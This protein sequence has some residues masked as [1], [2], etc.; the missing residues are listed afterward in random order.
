MKRLVFSSEFYYIKAVDLKKLPLKDK[1]LQPKKHQDIPLVLLRKE[2]NA[3]LVDA[4]KIV[5]AAKD[6]DFIKV[7]IIYYTVPSFIGFLL[8]LIKPIKRHYYK[9]NNTVFTVRLSDIIAAKL[10]R[11]ER[12]AENA[13][14]WNNKRWHIS[15]EEASKR[16]ANLKKS[17]QKKGY[18][19]KSP[20]FVMLNRKFGAKDQLFQGHHRVGICKELGVEEVSITFWTAPATFTWLKFLM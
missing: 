16:Y 13:Y 7:K 6:D 9:V 3:K 19:K 17:I 14:Q 5:A 8:C 2:G 18:D 1:A 4:K 20:M 12:N 15:R 10:P 11:G